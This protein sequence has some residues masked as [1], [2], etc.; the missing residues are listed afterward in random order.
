[1]VVLS[2]ADTTVSDIMGSVTP[3][4]LIDGQQIPTD[5]SMNGWVFDPSAG[6]TIQGKYIFGTQ[7]SVGQ[8]EL[9]FVLDARQNA[10][11]DTDTPEPDTPDPVVP[12]PPDAS[13]DASYDTLYYV[14]III[15]AAAGIA[16][17]YFKSR[18]SGRQ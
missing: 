10:T 4:R 13:S 1:M 12:D 6:A 2:G 15:A 18:R 17:F 3:T 14:L 16:A 7:T 9:V 8:D 5:I 11:P